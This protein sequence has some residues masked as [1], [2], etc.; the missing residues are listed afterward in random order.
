MIQRTGESE[1]I[2]RDI[3]P[4]LVPGGIHSN[5]RFI[6]PHPLWFSRAKGSRI[7]DVDQ[8]EYVDCVINMAALILG[9]CDERVTAAV[10]EQIDRGLTCGVETELNVRVAK[11]LHEMIPCAESVKFSNTG[12][13]AVMKAIMIARG[14]TGKEAII[15]AEGGYNG[16]QDTVAVSYNPDLKKAGPKKSPNVVP[17]SSGVLKKA[18]GSTIIMP[19]NDADVTEKLVK[20][21]RKKLAAVL[22]EPVAFNLGCVRPRE[23]YLRTLREIA[24]QY[25][26]LLIFDEIISGFRV[27]PGGAQEYYGVT[28]DIATF[29]KAIANGF[30]MSAVAARADIMEVTRPKNKVGWAGVYNASQVSMAASLATLEIIKDGEIQRKLND[31]SATLERKFSELAKEEKVQAQLLSFGGQ[32]QT[33]FTD[34]QIVDYRSACKADQTKF[35]VLREHML[36]EGIYMLPGRF[37][38]HGLVAAHSEADLNHITS[39]MRSGLQKIRELST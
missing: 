6:D 33:Y 13:E 18:T 19:Y 20:R 5:I 16:W 38:H 35:T 31:E 23:E 2:Y 32:F 7:W 3:S 8:N 12:T 25:G 24:D 15:K 27:A 21:Y 22:V 39:A 4:R 30:P 36:A 26:V 37:F 1:K 14:F 11:L 29:A 17:E 9:H 34:A 28:P 10:K